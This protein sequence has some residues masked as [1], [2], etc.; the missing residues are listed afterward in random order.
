MNEVETVLRRRL[1]DARN[2][3]GGWGYEAF[4]TSRLEPTCW[5]LLAL[6]EPRDEA[7]RLLAA[8]P[9][10]GGALLE[11]HDG[12]ANWSFHA[13]ALSTRLALGKAPA[14]ELHPLA[15]ALTEARGVAVKSSLNQRQDNSLQGWSWVD[16]TFS[17]VEPTAAALL[18]LKTCRAKGIVVA[19][20]DKR[21]RDGEAVLLDRLCVTGGWNYGNSNVFG[22]QLPAH[23]PTTAM[24]LL[25]LQDRAG[26]AFVERSLDYLEEHAV[27][28]AST[29]A[30]ALT[31][32]A[33]KKHG[34]ST[35]GVE[36]ELREWIAGQ[37]I[38]DMLS[39]GTALC[40]LEEPAADELFAY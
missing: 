20:L 6:R 38:T 17:W 32:L 9:S 27:S 40:A 2:G 24:A 29:R 16:D 21:I 33:L 25:A 8:W 34:R 30:L 26:E 19:G 28:S 15:N 35:T 22:Q 10:R 18:A 12:L 3:E 39:T 23:I 13:L 7:D 4:R 11:H 5:A 37:P 14:V 36:N 1:L 31:T